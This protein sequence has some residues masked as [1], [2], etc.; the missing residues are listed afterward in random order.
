M[1]PSH[2]WWIQNCTAVK[3]NSRGANE[4]SESTL[5]HSF[6][7]VTDH[8][9]TLS[10]LTFSI[11]SQ[12][13]E[14]LKYSTWIHSIPWND[15]QTT[16]HVRVSARQRIRFC[17]VSASTNNTLLAQ[18]TNS[19]FFLQR[20][21]KMTRLSRKMCPRHTPRFYWSLPHTKYSL[22]WRTPPAPPWGLVR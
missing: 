3:T 6:L 1:L 19:F 14:L 12:I 21:C 18:R 22:L 9:H 4:V 7:L 2:P 17:F 11:S 10:P 20:S 16:R 15:S 5:N 8:T 13:T